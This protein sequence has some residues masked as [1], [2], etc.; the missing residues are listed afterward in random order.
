MN[1]FKTFP[2]MILAKTWKI[3]P[4]KLYQQIYTLRKPVIALVQGAALSSGCGLAC[5]CDFIIAAHE[6]A[7]F[8]YTE[9]KLGFIPAIVMIYLVRRIGEGRAREF[10][11]RGDLLNADEAL[12]MGLI[13]RIVPIVELEEAGMQ[14]ANKLITNNTGTSVGLVKELLA[15]VHGMATDDALEYASNLNALA[16]M[17]DDCKRGIVAYLKT[18][19]NKQ[20]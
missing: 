3:P 6:T 12:T 5:V 2:N 13:S 10:V 15:R 4:M 7:K 20:L 1:I 11:L 16:R 17:T 14:L 8:G 18:D 19:S 9:L